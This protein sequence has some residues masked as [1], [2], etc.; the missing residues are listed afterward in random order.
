MGVP[1]A[2]MYMQQGAQS[3]QAGQGQQS[4]NCS[5][6]GNGSGSLSAWPQQIGQGQQRE[7][8]Q[9]ETGLKGTTGGGF[10][11]LGH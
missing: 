3:S 6:L 4:P 9:R 7:G 8:Q 5:F 10:L 2:G 1:P 11:M